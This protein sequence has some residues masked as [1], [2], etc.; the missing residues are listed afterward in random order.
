MQVRT[1]DYF[2]VAEIKVF[3]SNYTN[4]GPVTGEIIVPFCNPKI[5]SSIIANIPKLLTRFS[6]P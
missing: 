1:V 2:V 4:S 6:L 3:S 5:W